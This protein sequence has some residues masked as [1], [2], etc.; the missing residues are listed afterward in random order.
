MAEHTRKCLAEYFQE[1]IDGQKTWELRLGDS[2]IIGS[3]DILRLVEV[4]TGGELTGREASFEVGFSAQLEPLIRRFYTRAQLK[5][6]GLVIYS[7]L[8]IESEA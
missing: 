8:P 2:P 4:T 7:L 1:I 3:G 5:Q 6:H